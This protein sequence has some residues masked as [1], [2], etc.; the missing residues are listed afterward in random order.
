LLEISARLNAG[1]KGCTSGTRREEHWGSPE[2]K[3]KDEVKK[4]S[5]SSCFEGP[6][7]TEKASSSEAGGGGPTVIRMGDV[8]LGERLPYPRKEGKKAWTEA[9]SKTSVLDPLAYDSTPGK[10]RNCIDWHRDSKRL[11]RKRTERLNRRERIM[12][13]RA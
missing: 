1:R 13:P 4:R 11:R 12:K 8:K 10:K 3:G 6:R 5:R 2:R 9:E 7:R